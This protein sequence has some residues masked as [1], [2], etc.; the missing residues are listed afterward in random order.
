M[1]VCVC[2]C[3]CVCRYVCVYTAFLNH[4]CFCVFFS[5]PMI[6]FF[7]SVACLDV[8]VLRMA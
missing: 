8:L 6:V 2:V 7:S 5:P 3:V 4:F 1:C